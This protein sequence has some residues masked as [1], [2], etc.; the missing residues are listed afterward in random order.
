MREMPKPLMLI[1]AAAQGLA[2]YALYYAFDTKSWPSDSPVWSFPLWTLAF[3]VPLLLLLSLTRENTARAI[4]DVAIVGAVFTLLAAYVGYQAEP[5]RDIRT[6]SLIFAFVA[7]MTLAAF[8]ALMYLQQRVNRE[9]LTYPVLFTN[10]WRNFLVGVLS[11]IFVVIFWWILIL[12]AQLFRV[13][14]INF[15][16]ELFK[17]EWFIFPVLSLAFGIGVIIFRDLTN[18]IDSITRLLHWLCKLLL[19]LVVIV[20]AVF[21]A[22]LPFVGLDVLWSTGSGTALLL[23]L[24]ALILFFTNAVYQD[25]RETKP[26][27]AVVHRLIYVGL[28]F[29]PLL[30]ALSFYGLI[31]RLNQYGWSVERCWAFVTWLI[32]SLFAIGYVFGIV[33]RRSLWTTELARVNIIMGVVVLAIMLLANSPILDFRKIS[34]ASQFQRVE[35]GEI[36]LKDFDFWYARQHLAR[37]AYLAMEEIKQDIGDSDPELLELIQNPYNQRYGA[38]PIDKKRLWENMRYRP[39]QFELP[40]G[41]QDFVNSNRHHNNEV[42]TTLIQVDLDEDGIDEYV[43]TSVQNDSFFQAQLFYRHNDAWKTSHMNLA[44]GANAKDVLDGEISLVPPRFK[45]LRIGDTT[46]NV[47]IY[48]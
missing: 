32:L 41:L 25:G 21:V 35:S 6:G 14:E 8:K 24:L 40:D 17:Q 36:E 4:R 39:T 29:M 7:S 33:R 26:Y 23:W 47:Y 1:I 44:S 18:V 42:E 45:N 27:P 19:P 38:A 13:I 30:A 34:L 16:A 46:L 28:C 9:A 31:L 37:P 20:A 5:I 12:W 11:G 43:L 15:F 2:L 22:A 48:D 3:A 10:S